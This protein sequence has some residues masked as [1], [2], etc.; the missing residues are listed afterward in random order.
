[1]NRRTDGSDQIR[2]LLFKDNLAARTFEVPLHWIS[3]VG[4]LLGLLVFFSVCSIFIAAKYY[5]L[6]QRS[7]PS[8]AEELESEI[9]L[10]KNS[11][12][13]LEKKLNSPQTQGTSQP[14][15]S[16]ETLSNATLDSLNYLGFPQTARLNAPDPSTLSFSVRNPKAYWSGSNLKV[17]L[18]LQYTKGD[19][20]NQQGYIVI[21]AKGSDGIDAYPSGV[22]DISQKKI[23]I[24]ITKGESFSVSRFREVKA[25][26]L[27]I[28]QRAKITGST[29]TTSSN[30]KSVEVYIFDKELQ[31]LSLVPLTPEENK[32][33]S[34]SDTTTGN[35]ETTG[36][37]ETSPPPSQSSQENP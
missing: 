36:E 16:G 2:V 18:S 31:L 10:L 6:S 14:S 1:M 37:T 13:D 32:R 23:L 15:T 5:W 8:H 34:S 29:S 21:L 4:T 17:R 26:F 9:S 33:G 12:S 28:R 20:G 24:D 22:L 30:D 3:W 7:S 19:E 25:D 11:L 35:P 27:G